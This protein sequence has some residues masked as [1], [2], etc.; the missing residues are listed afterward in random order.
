MHYVAELQARGG[1][2]SF[3]VPTPGEAAPVVREKAKEKVGEESEEDDC[4]NFSD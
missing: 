4:E 1:T 3:V 2:V